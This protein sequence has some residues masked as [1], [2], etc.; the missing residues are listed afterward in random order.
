MTREVLEEF[1]R[2][3]HRCLEDIKYGITGGA[4]LAEYGMECRPATM[5]VIVQ[6]EDLDFAKAKLLRSKA[7]FLALDADRTRS[8]FLG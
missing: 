4:A 6:P 1:A 7:G 5:E 8:D 3:L 2:A